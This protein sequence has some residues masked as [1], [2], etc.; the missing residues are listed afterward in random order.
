MNTKTTFSLLLILISAIFYFTFVNAFKVT[1][2]DP[3]SAE[4]EKLQTA[5]NRATEQLSL[6]ALRIKKQQLTEQNQSIIQNF[7]PTTLHSGTFVYN[8]AQL[9]N[10]SGLII[11]GLQYTVIDD[12]ATNPNGQKKLLVEFNMDGRYE[13]FSNWVQI[14]ER[15]NVLIDIES[16]SGIKTTNTGETISFTVKLYTYGINID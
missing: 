6:K 15:S 10:Q 2:V 1:A 3:V 7:V 9:A 14:L 8:I 5:Y 4:L 16:I 11:K 13:S 12:T